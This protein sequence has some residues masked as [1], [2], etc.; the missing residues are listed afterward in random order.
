WDAAVARMHQED[1]FVMVVQGDSYRLAPALWPKG[2]A[3]K[4]DLV[5]VDPF[6]IGDKADEP[7]NILRTLNHSKVPFMCWT[8]LFSVPTKNDQ[9]WPPTKWSFENDAQVAGDKQAQEFVDSCINKQYH[10]A[11]F[12]WAKSNGARQKMFGCQLTIGN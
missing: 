2:D 10:L 6:K 5:F 11:W 9:Q 8:P 7:E 4:P 1:D 3:A 12:S